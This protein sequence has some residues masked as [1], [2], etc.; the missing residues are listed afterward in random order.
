[1]SSFS[2]SELTELDPMLLVWLLG[3]RG[4]VLFIF[5]QCTVFFH[6]TGSQPQCIK[7]KAPSSCVNESRDDYFL[8]VQLS[9]S[10]GLTVIKNPSADILHKSAVLSFR[11]HTSGPKFTNDGLNVLIVFSE[12]GIPFSRSE[13]KCRIK[14]SPGAGRTICILKAAVRKGPVSKMRFQQRLKEVRKKASG[15]L[16]GEH[17]SQE[18]SHISWRGHRG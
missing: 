16:G 4:L 10:E 13:N 11:S 18:K 12:R 9:V 3:R 8:S 15:N 7:P 5:P 17:G 2:R 6:N 1:M 14:W